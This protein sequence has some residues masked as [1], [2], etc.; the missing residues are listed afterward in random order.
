[1]DIILNLCVFP[2]LDPMSSPTG[3][4]AADIFSSPQPGNAKRR[5][6]QPAASSKPGTE[7]VLVKQLNAGPPAERRPAENP[8][9][10]YFRDLADSLSRRL[11]TRVAIKRRGRRGRLEIE[12]YGD[13]DLNRLI[14]LLEKV[15][16]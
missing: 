8:E 15:R 9:S 10:I 1:M 7:S 4:S 14:G 13:D 11:G 2:F 3:P 16:L 12:F 6:F 5:L